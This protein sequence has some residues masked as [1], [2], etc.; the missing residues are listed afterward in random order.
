MG[1]ISVSIVAQTLAK[2]YSNQSN[3]ILKTK[4]SI[5]IILAINLI[6]KNKKWTKNIYESNQSIHTMI[7]TSLIHHNAKHLELYTTIDSDSSK[8]GTSNI[9]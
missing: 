9:Q 2:E 3:K 1:H 5:R 8:R 7:L 6:K 4:I